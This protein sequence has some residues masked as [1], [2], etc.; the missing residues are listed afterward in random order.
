MW[1]QITDELVSKDFNKPQRRAGEMH[2]WKLSENHSFV[3]GDERKQFRENNCA[4]IEMG[5]S[6]LSS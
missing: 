2:S 3:Q 1:E 5:N 4:Q 6:R